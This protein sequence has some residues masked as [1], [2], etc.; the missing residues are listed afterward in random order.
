MNK[1][2]EAALNLHN[3]DESNEEDE[4]G[5]DEYNSCDNC[6]KKLSTK[7]ARRVTKATFTG[8]CLKC[9]NTIKE[10]EMV[11]DSDDE[12]GFIRPTKDY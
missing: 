7:K 12:Y 9:F 11:W 1:L 10:E 6:G 2:M 8:Y 5:D 3:D 4:A